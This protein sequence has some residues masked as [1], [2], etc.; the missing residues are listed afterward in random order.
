MTPDEEQVFLLRQT[1]VRKL[2]RLKEEYAKASGYDRV[3]I[4][5]RIEKL[6]RI[7]GIHKEQ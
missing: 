2:D 6:E 4:K 7:L 1:L 5:R 3:S